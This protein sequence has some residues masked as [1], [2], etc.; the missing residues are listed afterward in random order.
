MVLRLQIIS[1]LFSFFYGSFLFITLEINAKFIYSS[2]LII[3]IL[4][5]ILF[6]LFHTLLYFVILMNINFGYIHFYFF[7][8]ILL[9]YYVCKVIYKRF[10]KRKKL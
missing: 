5:T 8:C 1:L 4:G 6:V 10:V 7:L 3:K 9:G 2:N